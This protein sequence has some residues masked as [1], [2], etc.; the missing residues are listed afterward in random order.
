MKTKELCGGTALFLLN[1]SIMSENNKNILIQ[2]IIEVLSGEQKLSYKQISA[3]IKI[4]DRSGREQIKQIL[5]ELLQSKMV[6]MYGRGKYGLHPK[7]HLNENKRIITGVVDMKP[8]GKAYIIPDDKTMEDV[9]IQAANVN[10]ALHGDIVKILLFPQRKSRKPEGEIIEILER[11]QKQIVGTIKKERNFSYFIPDNANMPIN[12]IIPNA[13]LKQAKN[14]EKVVIKITNWSEHSK[15]PF[16]VVTDVLGKQG[17]NDVEMSSILAE[18]DF[19]LRFPEDVETEAKNMETKINAEEIGRRRDFRPIFTITID[20]EDAKDFD[21]AI[22][23]RKINDK[24]WELGVHIADV[25]FYVKENSKIDKEAFSR[26]TSV[27]LVDRVIPMLP[28]ALSNNLCSLRPHEDKLCFSAV[29]E[30]D[31]SGKIHKEWFGKTVINSDRRFNYAEVQEIIEQQTGEF[32]EEILTLDKLAKI[33]RKDRYAKGAINFETLDVKFKLD[34]KGKPVGVYFKE[35]KD[36]NHLIEEF[37]LLANKKTAEKIGKKTS[38]NQTPKTFVY[39]IHDEPNTERLTTF[40][41]FMKRL[42]YNIKTGNRKIFAESLNQ[43]FKDTKEN[44]AHNMIEKLS[45]RIMSR[46]V[47]STQN[48]G[49]YGL[50]FPYYTHFT[51]PIRRYPDLMTHRLLEHYLL[52]N[53]SSVN[54]TLFEEHCKHCSAREQK[55]AEAERNSIKYKQAEFMADKIGQEFKATITG[56]SKWGLFAETDDTKCEGLIS[57]RTLDD[58]YYY[59]DENNYT[60]VGLHKGKNYRIGDSIII[61]VQQ[62]D[63]SKKQ[64]GYVLVH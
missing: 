14:G 53:Q 11:S 64:L 51:S 57:M 28:E 22:S 52:K 13:D 40:K 31:E 26:G 32:C 38:K 33:L 42:G 9:F 2:N 47:Y 10:R 15:N 61:K 46:A 54:E 35:S 3:K 48:I 36:S 58:D 8:T 20:P 39:R 27:Y 29:F 7:L 24:L 34:D 17:D 5:R 18:F 1:R 49:H 25:S 45:I 44:A 56:V 37:M 4:F 41:D 43:L 59:L 16:G 63:L 50:A 21:D 55:A 6:K 62:V 30:M 12:V 23:L 60:L 19:P